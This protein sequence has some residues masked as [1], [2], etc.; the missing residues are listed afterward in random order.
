MGKKYWGENIIG[1]EIGKRKREKIGRNGKLFLVGYVFR[2]GK[3]TY[4]S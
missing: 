2:G 3:G 1:G 4:P